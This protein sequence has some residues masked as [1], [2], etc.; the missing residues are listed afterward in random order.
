MEC[1][2][3]EEGSLRRTGGV[4][5]SGDHEEPHKVRSQ[6]EMGVEM[7]PKLSWGKLW[8]RKICWTRRSPFSAAE[9]SSMSG[10]K[11]PALE[12]LSKPR[13]GKN[14]KKSSQQLMGGLP[15]GELGGMPQL[16]EL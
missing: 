6:H 11:C 10:M 7:S 9:V 1:T 3:S 16:K 13:S 14:V 12:H 15:P 5:A 2:S 8:R 4:D